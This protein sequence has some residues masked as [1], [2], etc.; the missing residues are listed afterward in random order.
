M[1]YKINVN[2]RLVV[3][4]LSIVGFLVSGYLT[5][6]YFSDAKTSFCITGSSCDI[7]RESIFSSI[8]GL[9]VSLIGV[10][11][12]FAIFIISVSTITDRTKWI[13]LYILALV[14]FVFS[15]YLTYLELFVIKAIC[16]Y[17]IVSA[18]VM[19]GIFITL[20][21]RRGLFT[22]FSPL[23]LVTSSLIICVIVIFGAIFLYSK[24]VTIAV[25]ESSLQF[26]L[27]KHLDE[28]GAKMYGS[29]N[30][31]HCLAQKHFFG[32]AFKYV[33]YV[34]CNPKGRDPNPS[35]CFDKGI[36][37]YPTWEITGRYYTGAKTLQDLSTI[38]GYKSK[39]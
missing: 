5:H 18:L 21:L 15:A 34:E 28:I 19:T 11:G 25:T 22:T 26:K 7:V 30:C 37:S 1:K 9:P 29:Y 38:S 35:I 31:P 2:S 10:I 3:N 20:L 36:I 6:L 39:N 23:R 13:A 8:L 4:V 24:N 32:K 27:A 14:G 33:N 16:V 17:C 12:Y